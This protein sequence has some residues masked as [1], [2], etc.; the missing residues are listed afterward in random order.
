[1]A[2]DGKKMA[3]LIFRPEVPY[4]DSINVGYFFRFD[5]SSSSANRRKMPGINAMSTDT[6]T[7]LLN[8]TEG[9]RIS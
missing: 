7:L 3:I 6:K 4:G 5:S 8:I 9:G 1:M 2:H